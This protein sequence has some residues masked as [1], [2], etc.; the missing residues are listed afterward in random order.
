MSQKWDGWSVPMFSPIRLQVFISSLCISVE[1]WEGEVE[2]VNICSSWIAFT[3]LYDL[4]QAVFRKV[5]RSSEF[6]IVGGDRQGPTEVSAPVK[7]ILAPLVPLYQRNNTKQMYKSIM[8]CTGTEST[9]DKCLRFL[10]LPKALWLTPSI[11]FYLFWRPPMKKDL[12]HPNKFGLKAPLLIINCRSF[13]K[14]NETIIV[15]SVSLL[16]IWEL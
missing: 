11:F 14:L 12:P 10:E 13:M 7:R 4:Y 15:C 5:R 2:K 8:I 16:S 1:V 9:T 3:L 6:M